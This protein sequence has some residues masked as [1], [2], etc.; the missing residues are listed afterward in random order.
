VAEKFNPKEGKPPPGCKAILLCERIMV[1]AHTAKVSLIGIVTKQVL[2]VFPGRTEPMRIFLHLVDG[3]GD[4][5]LT[6]EVHDLAEDRII[7]RQKGPRISF[8]NRPGAIQVF[9]KLSALPIPHPDKYDVL[10][11]ADGIEIERQQVR[12]RVPDEEGKK[13]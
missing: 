6:V 9:F 4:Y 5:Q 3:I 1:E 12:V 2:S 13:T 10:V 11:L 8:P 7:A